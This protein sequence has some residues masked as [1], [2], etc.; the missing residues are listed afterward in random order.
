MT[1]QA[2]GRCRSLQYQAATCAGLGSGLGFRAYRVWGAGSRGFGCREWS[3]GHHAIHGF[4]M[5]LCSISEVLPIQTW[6]KQL[7]T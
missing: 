5:L 4:C 2:S 7:R 3:R 6:A 1:F